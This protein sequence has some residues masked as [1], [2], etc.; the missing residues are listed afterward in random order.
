MMEETELAGPVM[1]AITA[2]LNILSTTVGAVLGS[3]ISV[4]ITP[5]IVTLGTTTIISMTIPGAQPVVISLWLFGA[6]LGA[7]LGYF[8]SKGVKAL[9][10]DWIEDKLKY[11]HPPKKLRRLVFREG[12]IRK[13]IEKKRTELEKNIANAFKEAITHEK[14]EA[15]LAPIKEDLNKSADVVA[16]LIK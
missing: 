6:A 9:L 4:P 7:V 1:M 11:G 16:I 13:K 8:T 5:V 3:S 2:I 12:K 10:G 15:I 14:L